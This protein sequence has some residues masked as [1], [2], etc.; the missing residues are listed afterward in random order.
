MTDCSA[1]FFV[2]GL[3]ILQLRSRYLIAYPNSLYSLT[4]EIDDGLLF[5][6]GFMVVA[7]AKVA[8][9]ATHSMEKIILN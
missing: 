4:E 8:V 2:S 6:Q 7:K 3:D 9:A 1:N 5:S